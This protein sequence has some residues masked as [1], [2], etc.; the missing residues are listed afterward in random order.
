MITGKRKYIGGWI[1][2]SFVL[3]VALVCRESNENQTLLISTMLGVIQTVIYTGLAVVWGIS[4]RRR[5][6]QPQIR[7]LLEC[8]SALVLFWFLD[9][10]IKYYALPFFKRRLWI[11]CKW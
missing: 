3:L 5:I 11:L 9:R 2:Y 1:L 7:R 6:V 10:G 4:V 8:V